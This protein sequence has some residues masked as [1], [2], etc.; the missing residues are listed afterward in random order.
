M[1]LMDVPSTRERVEEELASD[2]R[3]DTRR[4]YVAIKDGIVRLTGVVHTFAEKTAAQEAA[5]RALGVQDVANDIMVI[6]A[7][8][9]PD[10]E[11]ARAV[12][13]TLEW[14]VY[15]PQDRIQS[16]VADGWVV[17][18]GHVPHYFQRMDAG[19]AIRRLNGVRGVTNKIDVLPEDAAAADARERIRQAL[20]RQTGKGGD[21]I[22]IT[23]HDGSLTLSGQVRNWAERKAVISAAAHMPGVRAVIDDLCVRP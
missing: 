13:H 22:A 1:T 9:R 16:T 20:K 18:T 10:V 5:H 11:I 17:L 14:D 12:R 6:P 21:Q 7:Q 23:I 3:I 19:E 8:E 2:P 4:V 15:V